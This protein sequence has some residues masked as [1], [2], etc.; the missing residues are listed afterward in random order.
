MEIVGN[1]FVARGLA[2]LA[3]RHPRV[4]VLAAGVSS[5]QAAGKT[6]FDREA[7][8]V[9]EVLGRCRRQGAAVVF[10]STAS[11]AMYGSTDVPAAEH[12][13][14]FP[15]SPYGK[16]KYALERR[17]MDFPVSWLVL[18][19]SHLVGDGQRA[20]QLLPN[21]IQQIRSGTV[22]LRQGAH[23]DLIDIADLRCALDHLLEKEIT[24]EVVNVASGQPNRVEHIVQGIEDR[25]G[26]TARR[27][28]IP[29]PPARTVVST[30]KLCSLVPQIYSRISRDRYAESLLD[31]YVPCY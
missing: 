14:V 2:S 29:G 13:P 12:R 22:R 20:H 9:T 3:S 21:L 6:E 26:I 28:V 7:E 17:V 1:G 5:T 18:R 31:R 27:L 11:Q 8:L 23:R 30:E 19:L 25:L 16:H 4:T 10:L 15:E 24:G